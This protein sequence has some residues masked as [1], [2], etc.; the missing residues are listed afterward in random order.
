LW[1]TYLFGYLTLALLLPEQPA[2]KRFVLLLLLCLFWTVEGRNAFVVVLFAIF[3]R[4]WYAVQQHAVS[5]VLLGC[6]HA[7]L[8]G[9]AFLYSTDTGIYAL[10][11]LALSFAGAAWNGRTKS[12]MLRAYA[13]TLLAFTIASLV[14]VIAINA[15]MAKPFDFTVHVRL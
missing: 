6:C 1:C 2:W 4:G 14:L 8:C 15:F 3:L 13:S 9:A 5:P 7:L 12:C 10:A 11:G